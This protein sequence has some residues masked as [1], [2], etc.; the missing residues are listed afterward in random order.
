MFTLKFLHKITIVLAMVTVPGV[1]QGGSLERVSTKKPLSPW[2]MYAPS[3]ISLGAG[4]YGLNSILSHGISRQNMYAPM[5]ATGLAVAP[6]W[7]NIVQDIKRYD[8][9]DSYQTNRLWDVAPASTTIALATLLGVS[10]NNWFQGMLWGAGLS[11]PVL[12]IAQRFLDYGAEKKIA[13]ESNIIWNIIN[14]KYDNYVI[15][16]CEKARL[17]KALSVLASE[18]SDSRHVQDFTNNKI[19]QFYQINNLISLYGDVTDK[20]PY[21][22]LLKCITSQCDATIEKFKEKDA[23]LKALQEVLQENEGHLSSYSANIKEHDFMK[24]VESLKFLNDRGTAEDVVNALQDKKNVVIQLL[25]ERASALQKGT[26]VDLAHKYDKIKKFIENMYDQYEAFVRSRARVA[27]IS[28]QSELRSLRSKE[29]EKEREEAIVSPAGLAQLVR[30]DIDDQLEQLYAERTQLEKDNLEPWNKP[31]QETLAYT[32]KHAE[33]AGKITELNDEWFKNQRNR[34][35]QE[36][37][38]DAT[39]RVDNIK[40]NLNQA[41]KQ[42]REQGAS[43]DEPQMQKLASLR[44]LAQKGRLAGY[45]F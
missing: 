11:L 6:M 12:F 14:K 40:E 17:K 3:A 21:Y 26:M 33:I 37:D 7:T 4:L 27:E 24:L 10:K 2:K 43:D 42:L 29:A 16:Q 15:G 20:V 34:L 38:D 1:V 35:P 28:Q 41:M 8:L 45:H 5:L 31:A 25:S 39:I 44:A 23:A 32:K 36:R 13:E 22:N 30:T 18:L 9:R 19:I